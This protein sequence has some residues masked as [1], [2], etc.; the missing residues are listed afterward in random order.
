MNHTEISHIE[1]EFL[2]EVVQQYERRDVQSAWGMG[3]AARLESMI[4]F[5]AAALP[6]FAAFAILRSG[7]RKT[8]RKRMAI[9][10]GAPLLIV[11]PWLI[12]NEIA[13][14]GRVLYSSQSGPNAVQ[15]VLTTESR[16]QP[17]DSEKLQQNLGWERHQI[18]T[19]D[20][21]RLTLPSE[22]TL[23]RRAVGLAEE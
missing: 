3:W 8:L 2:S 18:E 12:R 13:F 4:R 11:T 17:G 9:A 19:N 15:G 23:D 7:A 21:S 10:L 16:T 6:M 1:C 20:P 22:A 5:N 14:R